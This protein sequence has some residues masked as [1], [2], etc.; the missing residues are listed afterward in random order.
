MASALS[1]NGS[2]EH[3]DCGNN[4][5]LRQSV[6]TYMTWVK[7]SGT[8]NRT[9]FGFQGSANNPQ[10]RVNNSGNL[11]LLKTGVTVIA[12]ST[13]TLAN[14]N[15]YHVAVTYDA[16]GNYVFYINGSTSGSGTNLVAFSF[17]GGVFKIGRQDSGA[18]ELFSG[19]ID[20]PHVYGAVLSGTD[21]SNYYTGTEP[22]TTDLKGFW[23]FDEGT[24]TSAADETTTNNG[25]LVNT[26][27]WV[28]AI[29]PNGAFKPRSMLMGAG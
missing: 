17:T 7:P 13:G 10:F 9:I 5:S 15:V 20:D 18:T 28:A 29:N 25:T 23:K 27:T 4:A 22:A 16:S 1:F 8:G 24:G 19:V 11:E 6:L 21:I 3:V 26:P 14:D 2:D 12:T